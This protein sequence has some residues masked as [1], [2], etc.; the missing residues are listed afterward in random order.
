[1]GETCAGNILEG[2][3]HLLSSAHNALKALAAGCGAGAVPHD[4]AAGQDVLD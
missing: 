3:T 1:M 2:G 4:D